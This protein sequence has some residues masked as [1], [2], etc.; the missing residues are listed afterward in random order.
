MM[1]L[2]NF[3]QIVIFVIKEQTSK[4]YA[5]YIHIVGRLSEIVKLAV[6]QIILPLALKVVIYNIN[7]SY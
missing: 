2:R 7:R 4:I 5:K 3:M 1:Q 6:W